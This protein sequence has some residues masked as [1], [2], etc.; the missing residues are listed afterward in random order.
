MNVLMASVS[1]FVLGCLH[2]FDADHLTAVTVFASR[3]RSRMAA[4]KF[5]VVWGLG[6]TTTLFLLGVA[7]AAFKFVIPPAV[8]TGSELFVGLLLIAIGIWALSPVRVGRQIRIHRHEHDGVEHA[9]VVSDEEGGSRFHHHSMFAVGAAHGFA[10]TA[11]VMVIVPL[12]IAESLIAVVA[13]LILFGLGTIVAMSIFALTVGT[14]SVEAEKRGLVP[15]L[16]KFAGGTSIV[17]GCIWIAL[18]LR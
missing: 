15:Y 14:L 4:I 6:H 2:A 5:G 18:V 9:H 7:T 13:Y 12:T 10:G 8:Q 1:G 3:S 17:V 11:A 16:R